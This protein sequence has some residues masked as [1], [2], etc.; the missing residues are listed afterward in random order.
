MKISEDTES[1]LLKCLECPASDTQIV[2]GEG[3][4]N[5][6]VAIV[7]DSPSFQ[8]I[9][10]K[11]LFIGS[12]GKLLD[13]LL[14]HYGVRRE[15]CWFTNA[16]QCRE[17]KK[18][19]PA[20]VKACDPRLISELKQV[21]PEVIIALGK[22]AIEAVMGERT[23]VTSARVGPP[24]ES[25]LFPGVK[26]IATYHPGAALRNADMFPDLIADFA[27]IDGPIKVGWE[28]PQYT[29]VDNVDFARQVIGNALD[30]PLLC[31]DIEVGVEKDANFSHPDVLLCVGFAWERG[32]VWVLSEEMCN[33]ST[34]RHL[35]GKMLDMHSGIICHNGKFDLQVLAR[36]GL[37]SCAD[38]FF[39]TMLASYCLDERQGVHGLKYISTELL[40][41]PAYDLEVKQYISGGESFANIPR[42]L[43]YKYNAFDVA[44]TM[45]LYEHYNKRLDVEG[46][47][48]LHRML[49]EASNNLMVLELQGIKVDTEYLDYLTEHYLDELA[50]T[51]E[52]LAKWV[53][54]PRSPKQVKEQLWDMGHRVESTNEE[55]LRKINESTSP[56]NKAFEFTKL[57]LH[58]RKEHKLY[59]TY[60]KGISTRLIGGRVYPTFLLH[61]T[62]T[63]RL[64]CRNPN[65]QNVPRDSKIRKLFV[66]EEG[67][68]FVQ[69]DY[70]QAELR[71]IAALAGDRYLQGVFNEDRDLHSEVATRFYGPN[72][73]KDQRVRAKAVVFGLAYGR[74]A[75]SLAQEYKIPVE[76]AQR[77]LDTFFETIP[78]VVKWREDLKT[79]VLTNS[80]TL[81]SPFGRRRRFWLITK[82]NQNDVLKETYNFLPQGIASDLTLLALGEVQKR[83]PECH[84]R[85][86]VHDSI[87]VECHKS[88]AEYVGAEM[89][90]IMSEVAGRFTEFVKFPSDAQI[91]ASWGE[92]D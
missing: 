36:I 26:I 61:G 5:A 12:T 6:R 50:E 68:V 63:G 44:L 73:T 80:E 54:N 76:E 88:M 27:K 40:G 17:D 29:I 85:L 58:Y 15:E 13:T 52:S 69:A 31:L 67:N 19:N 79:R 9:T 83:I 55:T 53:E 46:L 21:N 62:V 78:E 49:V 57:M 65:L 42:P 43:L 81:E 28:A 72:F 86:P 74:E 47:Q 14:H 51:E 4:P 45:E 25:K 77:Y 10:E 8:E 34:V 2:V 70:A 87:L 75:Y 30:H 22:T 64:A 48:P 32:Q 59:G 38:L 84:V 18:V 20:A 24:K 91:G 89:S 3:N 7:G 35:L 60:V 11:A 33:N 82:E 1:G 39:D 41:A 90:S 71:V 37:T 92:L 66:P 23:S 56:G 16:T